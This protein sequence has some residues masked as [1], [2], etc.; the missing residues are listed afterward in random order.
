MAKFTKGQKKA[1]YSG[2][3]YRAGQ[4]GVAIPFKS[5]RNKESFRQGYKNA[6]KA[7]DG[8]PKIK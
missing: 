5:E 6:A 7:V 2:M 4:K 1:Y 8:Y 3:G